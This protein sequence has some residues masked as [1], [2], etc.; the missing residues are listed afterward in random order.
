MK[1]FVIPANSSRPVR[2][3]DFDRDASWRY[4]VTEY[5]DPDEPPYIFTEVAFLTK[6]NARRDYQ[7]R[8]SRA[9][10]YLKNHSDDLNSPENLYGD[11]VVL[12]YDNAFEK[13]TDLP[14]PHSP[15]DFEDLLTRIV[16]PP[17]R[18]PT[19]AENEEVIRKWEIDH[20]TEPAPAPRD[21]LPHR[22][23]PYERGGP[24][25]RSR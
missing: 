9:S 1:A 13:L 2:E 23:D 14:W 6:E 17:Q 10:E 24:P 18:V 19:E 8:N 7:L 25:N 5:N 16:A 20:P 15:G 4:V 12:G 3:T 21:D 22:P 11:V